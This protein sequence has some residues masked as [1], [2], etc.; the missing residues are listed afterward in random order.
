M[1]KDAGRCKR[2]EPRGHVRTP[3]TGGQSSRPKS[4][5]KVSAENSDAGASGVQQPSKGCCDMAQKETAPL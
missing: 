1:G 5:C 2:A 4:P 3:K